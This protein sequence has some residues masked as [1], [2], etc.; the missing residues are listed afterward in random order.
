MVYN[1]VGKTELNHNLSFW[2]FQVTFEKLNSESLH[3]FLGNSLFL[4]IVVVFGKD[5]IRLGVNMSVKQTWVL[6]WS[7]GWFPQE[8]F[9]KLDS[10]S[11]YEVLIDFLLLISDVVLRKKMQIF[12]SSVGKVAQNYSLNRR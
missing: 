5:W 10:V 2:F 8:S 1:S 12:I 6:I 7:K 9:K 3:K 4:I 11:K